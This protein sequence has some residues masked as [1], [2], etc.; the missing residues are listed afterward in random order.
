MVRES[1]GVKKRWDFCSRSF[2][3]R[4]MSIACLLE[5]AVGKDKPSLKY[6][7][8]STH[9][10]T[11]AFPHHCVVST[12]GGVGSQQELPGFIDEWLSNTQL[13]DTLFL[14]SARAT[15]FILLFFILSRQWSYQHHRKGKGERRSRGRRDGKSQSAAPAASVLKGWFHGLYGNAGEKC[16]R[17]RWH[18]LETASFTAKANL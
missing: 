9:A 2:R 14:Q 8:V 17:I 1:L 3:Q 12:K 5:G 7:H 10:R 18:L 13:S 11:H 6:T 16:W 15:V 4:G